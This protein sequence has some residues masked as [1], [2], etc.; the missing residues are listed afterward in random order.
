MLGT[1]SRTCKAYPFSRSLT[2][3]FPESTCDTANYN[4]VYIY[5]SILEFCK[6]AED[7][8]EFL[9]PAH[10]LAPDENVLLDLAHVD[11]P[12]GVVEALRRSTL[13]SLPP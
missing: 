3:N 4:F 13:P 1:V 6:V 8:E 10:S 11:P 12:A 2:C 5:F 9:Q 7:I